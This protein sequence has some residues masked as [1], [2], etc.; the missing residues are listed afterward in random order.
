MQTNP[1]VCSVPGV[2]QCDLRCWGFRLFLFKFIW[3]QH[4]LDP[5]KWDDY[6]SQMGGFYS[7]FDPSL[8]KCPNGTK[9]GCVLIF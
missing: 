4:L 3:N 6:Y 2:E 8:V 7:V 5:P 9:G 1:M